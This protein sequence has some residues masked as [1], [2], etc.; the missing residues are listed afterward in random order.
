VKALEDPAILKRLYD[1]DAFPAIE[2]ISFLK[3]LKVF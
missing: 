3:L 2:N 1:F